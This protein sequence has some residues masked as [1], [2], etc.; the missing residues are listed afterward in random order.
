MDEKTI[1][2]INDDTSLRITTDKDS[3]LISK[4]TEL[5]N[6]I[7]SISDKVENLNNDYIMLRQDAFIKINDIISELQLMEED[8]ETI[9][10]EIEKL[11]SRI[12]TLEKIFI[13]SFSLIMVNCIYV[14]ITLFRKGL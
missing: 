4:T 12:E 8:K 5:K 7:T 9:K 1:D 13:V 11:Y 2:K 3:L 6:E 14:I 10:N